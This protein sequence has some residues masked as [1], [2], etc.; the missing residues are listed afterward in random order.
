MAR[1]KNKIVLNKDT[2][3]KK[4]VAIIHSSNT[5]TLVQ[6]KIANALL[7]NAYARLLEVEEHEIHISE[8]CELIG[9]NSKDTK[10]IKESLIRLLST[11]LEWNIIDKTNDERNNQWNASSYI[12][13]AKIDGPICTYTFSKSLREL[14]YHPDQFGRISMHVQSKFKSSYGLALYENCNR[15]KDIGQTGW[16]QMDKFRKLMGVTGDKYK[17]FRDFKSRVLNKAIEEVNKYSPLTVT[18]RFKKIR[19]EITELQFQVEINTTKQRALLN[20]QIGLKDYL[21]SQFGTAPGQAESIICQYEESYIREKINLVLFSK[22]YKEG[23]IKNLSNYLISAL[24]NNF[25]REL[26]SKVK[27]KPEVLISNVGVSDDTELRAYKV[28][29]VRY[30]DKNIP[31]IYQSLDMH[32]QDKILKSFDTYMN[33]QSRGIYQDAYLREGLNNPLVKNEL[34]HFIK[35]D[36]NGLTRQLLTFEEWLDKTK[37]HNLV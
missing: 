4:H 31:L 23:K 5:F 12:A 36:K 37:M 21:I 24:E 16:I 33:N 28:E 8:L 30:I 6:R 14:L 34:Y 13:S 27:P 29:Y 7:F 19:S 22:S 17:I 2:E 20:N 15:Y 1:T 26:G 11:V 9:Y 10:P 25:K 3:F 35:K 32:E 18:P